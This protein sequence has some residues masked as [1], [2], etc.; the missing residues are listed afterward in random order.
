[1]KTSVSPVGV[2]TEMSYVCPAR[3]TPGAGVAGTTLLTP[4]ASGGAVGAAIAP[5][6]VDALPVGVAVG[7][8]VT[9]GVV[10]GACEA[11]LDGE[12]EIGAGPVV[13]PPPLHA[14]TMGRAQNAMIVAECRIVNMSSP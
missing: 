14:A 2:S 4:G 12:P 6:D 1:V 7:D 3:H 11:V 9:V 8:G 5:D 13:A 10:P